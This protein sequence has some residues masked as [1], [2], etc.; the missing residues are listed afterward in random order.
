M[1]KTLLVT[2]L[3]SCGVIAVTFL[4]PN[5]DWIKMTQVDPTK[6]Y[7]RETISFTTLLIFTMAF[8]PLLIWPLINIE[9]ECGLINR[10]LYL[11][12]FYTSLT[13]N[14]ATSESIKVI[15]EK[16]RPDYNSRIMYSKTITNNLKRQKV[17]KEGTKSFPSGHCA[18]GFSYTILT[19]YFLK[20][21]GNPTITSVLSFMILSVVGVI[22]AMTRIADNR[23]DI[24]DV[25][26]GI[27]VG[28]LV[29]LG[30][31]V[32]L[33]NKLNLTRELEKN[34][35]RNVSDQNEL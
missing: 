30:V 19:P 9:S 17:E 10:N 25:S 22:L 16:R 3:I 28:V 21:E 24:V 11:L 26:V 12:S 29:S 4:V 18:T 13:A 15:V 33:R 6:E 32:V 2:A 23:H 34:K 14:L 35:Q 1:Y 7:E 31:L 27:A 5:F 8:P 20:R